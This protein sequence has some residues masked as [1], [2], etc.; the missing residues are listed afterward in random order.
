MLHADTPEQAVENY[1]DSIT[2]VETPDDIAS[3]A[4]NIGRAE[5]IVDR[6]IPPG[7]IIDVVKSREG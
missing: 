2:P 4:E 1:R 3:H 5:L 7:A 6:D